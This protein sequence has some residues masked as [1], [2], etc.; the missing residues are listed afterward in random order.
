VFK[1]YIVDS[2]TFLVFSVCKSV[3]SCHSVKLKWH[4]PFVGSF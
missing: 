4:F 2:M 1:H 3:S